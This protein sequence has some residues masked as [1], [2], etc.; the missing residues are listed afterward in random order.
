MKIGVGK[1]MTCNT[2]VLKLHFFCDLSFE[3]YLECTKY[4]IFGLHM[5]VVH[6]VTDYAHK[7][8]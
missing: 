4:P 3:T 1:E 2:T 5:D 6:C 8:T 7:M